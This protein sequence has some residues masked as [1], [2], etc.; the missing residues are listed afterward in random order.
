MA[1]PHIGGA[2]LLISQAC[3]C[4]RR[5]VSGLKTLLENTAIHYRTGNPETRANNCGGDNGS[6]VPNNVYGYGS[7]RV[8]FAISKCILECK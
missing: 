2:I 5:N 3:P 1:S 4:Y 6:S 7:I 8:D